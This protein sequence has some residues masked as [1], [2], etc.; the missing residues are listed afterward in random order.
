MEQMVKD[1][2]LL[3]R[4]LQHLTLVVW[5][6]APS[7]RGKKNAASI[8]AKRAPNVQPKTVL[9]QIREEA[10]PDIVSLEVKHTMSEVQPAFPT[11]VYTLESENGPVVEDGNHQ[12]CRSEHVRGGAKAAP[13]RPSP[14]LLPCAQAI[15][16]QQS[17]P[18]SRL[19]RSSFSGFGDTE[20]VWRYVGSKK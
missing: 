1:I 8:T 13:A 5:P 7:G 9:K 20:A 19:Q 10:C 6:Q 16:P 3:P 12:T 4:G 11:G 17:R 15:I 14:P 18:S 2:V